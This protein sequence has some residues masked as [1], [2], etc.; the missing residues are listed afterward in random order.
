MICSDVC[1]VV[2]KIDGVD[3]DGVVSFSDVDA[4]VGVVILISVLVGTNELDC[5]VLTCGIAVVAFCTL[6]SKKIC[7][8]VLCN[9]L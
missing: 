6:I 4:F 5:V 1:V 7:N 9:H 3:V 2:C 8:E